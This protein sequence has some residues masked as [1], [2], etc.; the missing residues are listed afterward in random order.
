MAITL[1]QP[2]I[3]GDTSGVL[4]GRDHAENQVL[5]LGISEGFGTLIGDASLIRGRASGGND[6]LTSGTLGPNVVIGDAITITDRGRGGD[7]HVLAMSHG[8]CIALGDA[9]MLNER[10]RG[11]NDSV[12]AS[13]N[14]DVIAY[15]DAET[16]SG[17]AKG[18]NDMVTGR[19]SFGNVQVYGDAQTLSGSAAGGNDTLIVGIAF[20]G[21]GTQMYGDGAELLD[22]SKGGN[23]VLISAQSVNDRMWGDAAV[24]APTAKTGAD[25]FIFGPFNGRDTILD[26]QSGKDHIQLRDFGF[27]SFDDVASHLQSTSDG[28]VI[29]FD[30]MSFGVQD[31]I[32]V[33]GVAQLGASDFILS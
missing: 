30:T 5:T 3:F 10:A 27:T 1:D 20:P 18:G 16:M 28:A 33:V 26:F 15:G 9:L 12:E 2:E 19:S 24:V 7:D 25:T 31:S 13:A 14:S 6:T 8:G 22:R 29:A 32:L 11:G 21:Q 23:D 17:S 4:G